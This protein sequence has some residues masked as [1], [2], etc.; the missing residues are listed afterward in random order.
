[1]HD[2]AV[3]QARA[4]CYSQ[5]ALS[6]NDSS[7]LYFTKWDQTPSASSPRYKRH[8]RHDLNFLSTFPSEPTCSAQNEVD[9]KDELFFKE[10][11]SGRQGETF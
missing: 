10:G 2:W 1:M 8:L 11:T 7:T 6:S 5:A 4:G 3:W 9:V